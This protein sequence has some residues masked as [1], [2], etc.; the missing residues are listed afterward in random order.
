MSESNST[1]QTNTKHGNTKHGNTKHINTNEG[2]KTY[3][4]KYFP[5]L[6]ELYVKLDYQTQKQRDAEKD[7]AE[8]LEELWSIIY[9][10]FDVA[11]MA[12]NTTKVDFIK[13]RNIE[14]YKLVKENSMV[15]F[16]YNIYQKYVTSCDCGYCLGVCGKNEEIYK[17]WIDDE[18]AWRIFV[19][20]GRL[21]LTKNQISYLAENSFGEFF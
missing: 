8:E 17:F 12:F 7:L 4:K 18:T 11:P 14:K 13:M 20:Y 15:S 1:N 10:G 6:S 16:F 19:K 21:D 9:D 5:E 2:D 3:N